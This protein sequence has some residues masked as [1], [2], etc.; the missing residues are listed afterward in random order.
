MK[1]LERSNEIIS[2]SSRIAL[3]NL[4][5]KLD[6]DVTAERATLWL[7][8][9]DSI[10]SEDQFLVKFIDALKYSLQQNEI[11]IG[12]LTSNNLHK[13]LIAFKEICLTAKF[14][15]PDTIHYRC[16][17]LGSGI[18]SDTDFYR[19]H[20]LTKD[21]CKLKTTLLKYKNAIL[22]VT[23]NMM[24]FCNS[25]VSHWNCGLGM[26]QLIAVSNSTVL[27]KGQEMIIQAGIGEF[28]TKKASIF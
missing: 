5:G 4:K 9:A 12:P 17:I 11:K 24:S 21:T 10:Y 1:S 2:N 18:M 20:F 14:E 8:V 7:A 25:Q 27:R 22:I 6:D 23:N 3:E 13:K 19:I 26:V 15:F 28:S 16:R